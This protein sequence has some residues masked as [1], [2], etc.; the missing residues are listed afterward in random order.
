MHTKHTHARVLIVLFSRLLFTVFHFPF[1]GKRAKW[2]KAKIIWMKKKNYTRTN[3]S[4]YKKRKMNWLGSI[5]HRSHIHTVGKLVW[6]FGEHHKMGINNEIE[7]RLKIV[8]LIKTEIID[9]Q[10][11]KRLERKILLI[12]IIVTRRAFVSGPNTVRAVY[13]CW[14]SNRFHTTHKIVHSR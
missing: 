9:R 12:N 2:R 14:A 8:E 4:V 5:A 13:R 10:T 7:E 11:T 3:A 1:K 6:F